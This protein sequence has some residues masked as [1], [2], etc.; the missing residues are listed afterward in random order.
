MNHHDG[1]EKG[2]RDEGDREEAEE[3]KKKKKRANG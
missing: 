2:A 3:E 1:I